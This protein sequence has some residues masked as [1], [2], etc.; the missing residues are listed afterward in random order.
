[1]TPPED[2]LNYMDSLFLHLYDNK[3]SWDT[4]DD[5]ERSLKGTG[6]LL[7]SREDR[8]FLNQAW[9]TFQNNDWVDC[10]VKG[11][12]DT[13]RISAE[14]IEDYISKYGVN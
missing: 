2:L 6:V 10:K 13:F 12:G 8:E 5:I 7:D 9:Q 3:N 1:M 14:G 11:S 4:Y